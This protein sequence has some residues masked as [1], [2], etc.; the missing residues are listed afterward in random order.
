VHTTYGQFCPVA[1]GAEVFAERWT[2]L[3]MRELLNG[4]HRFNDLHRGLPRISRALLTQRLVS[5]ERAGLLQRRAGP[6]YHLTEAGLAL[7]P[8]IDALG[9]WGYHFAGTELRAEHLDAGLLMWFLRRRLR[10]A[11]LPAER[12]V[13]QFQFRPRG[14][15]PA[16]WLVTQPPNTDLCTTD[17]GH[18]IDLYVD[19]DLRAM[20]HVFLGRLNLRTALRDG[21]IELNGPSG[22]RRAFPTWIGISPFATT[23]PTR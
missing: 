20:A 19:A 7:R 14:H 10:V 8:V 9:R 1:L 17:P 2:P 13:V 12:T 23:E 21:C 5:L 11:N 4:S 3:I 6:E 16:F 22:L 15:P 18:D